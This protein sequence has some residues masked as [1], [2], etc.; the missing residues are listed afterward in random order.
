MMKV[1]RVGNCSRIVKPTRSAWIATALLVLAAAV[2]APAQFAKKDSRNRVAAAENTSVARA[3]ID[4]QLALRRT[5]RGER[6]KGAFSTPKQVAPVSNVQIAQDGLHFTTRVTNTYGKSQK[7]SGGD[8]LAP[9]AALKNL[10]IATVYNR[11]RGHSTLYSVESKEAHKAGVSFEWLMWEDKRDAELFAS[12]MNRLVQAAEN[13]EPVVL[14]SS[15][16]FKARVESWRQSASKPAQPEAVERAWV[17]AEAA[18][19]EKDF[20]SAAA[21]Y[22]EG[23]AKFDMWPEGYYNAAMVFAE[24]K[25]YAEATEHMRRYLEMVPDAPDAK[26]AR[27]NMYIWEEKA[28]RDTSADPTVTRELENGK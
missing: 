3:R 25:L 23:L 28:K 22:D 14:E 1:M 15:A 2:P 19:R 18:I 21:Y 17:L 26:A 6:W 11:V 10:S 5:Y 27:E 8:E 12:A 13:K 4:V 16:D 9:F 20:A 24:I 7:D